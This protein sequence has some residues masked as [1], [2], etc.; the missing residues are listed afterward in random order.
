MQ[1]DLIPF[2][3][4]HQFK[5]KLHKYITKSSI[6]KRFDF[7]DEDIQEKINFTMNPSRKTT[8]D[9]IKVAVYIEGNQ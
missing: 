2:L 7:G 1:D 8:N 4:K 9:L 6:E 5:T 3:A